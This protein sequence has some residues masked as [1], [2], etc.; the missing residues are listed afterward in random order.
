MSTQDETKTRKAAAVEQPYQ[1]PQQ[2][3]D[4]SNYVGS[5]SSKSVNTVDESNQSVAQEF[6]TNESIAI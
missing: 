3:E 2:P 6:K 1:V 4:F 5:F